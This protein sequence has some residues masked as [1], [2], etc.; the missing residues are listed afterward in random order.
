MS[1]TIS[2]LTDFN[3]FQS[4]TPL[5]HKLQTETGA[6]LKNLCS[7]YLNM[8]YI[9]ANDIFHLDHVEPRNFVP[10]E[11][12]YLGLAA[13]DSLENLKH[14]VQDQQQVTQ[15]LKTCFEFSILRTSYS[16]W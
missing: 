15:F 4:E 6:L 1:Y 3:T 7:N 13:I 11:N 14:E 2:L 12:I 8:S 5:L 9:R 16:I 10:L